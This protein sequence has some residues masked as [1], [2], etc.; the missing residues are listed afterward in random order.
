VIFRFAMQIGMLPLTGTTS[1]QHMQEDLAAEQFSLSD[2]EIQ[3][4]EM[5]A[6]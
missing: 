5:I 2:E 1:Q 4:I 6:F 3:R